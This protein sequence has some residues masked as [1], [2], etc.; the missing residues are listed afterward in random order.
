MAASSTST[1][2]VSDLRLPQSWLLS[3]TDKW[4]YHL[5]AAL[6]A[7]MVDKDLYTVQRLNPASTSKLRE[8]SDLLKPYFNVTLW[9]TELERI[10]QA[11]VCNKIKRIRRL[12]VD[13]EGED[14]TGPDCD[15]PAA[16]FEALDPG[17]QLAVMRRA[18]LRW[19]APLLIQLILLATERLGAL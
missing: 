8:I 19:G 14:D 12:H 2:P 16:M 18:V 1:S 4:P 3:K 15:T 5:T 6:R 11:K 17:E 9:D 13:E 7:L 10:L